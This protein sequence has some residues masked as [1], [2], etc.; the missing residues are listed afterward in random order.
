M[1][2]WPVSG[3]ADLHGRVAIVTGGARGIGR[4]IAVALADIGAKVLVGDILSPDETVATIKQRGGEA[5]GVIVDVRKKADVEGMVERAVK[6]WGTVHILINNAG[7]CT[8]VTL[9]DI[10]EEQWDLDMNTGV[11]GCLFGIQAVL[12]YMRKQQYGKIVNISS[13]SGEAGGA[14]S[15]SNETQEI[16]G[17]RSGPGYAANKG[18]IIAL[19]K[20]VAKD[21]GCD[22][23]YCNSVAPG[24]I[25]TP[26]TKGYDYGVESYPIAR[27]GKPEDIAQAVVFLASDMSNYT[28]GHILDVN[29]GS[30]MK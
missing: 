20:W 2:K 8:R 6:E 7:T 14:V 16:R 1:E 22:G 29:G 26:M 19:T 9:E 24:P 12:P 21:I 30:Y 13:V 25:E 5:V 27:V 28:T 17:S 3:K 11:K 10:T 15:K 18:A 23:I 4:A